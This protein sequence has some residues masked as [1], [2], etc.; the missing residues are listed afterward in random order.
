MVRCGWRPSLWSSAAAPSIV[1]GPAVVVG[2]LA[3]IPRVEVAA[4][5]D[6]LVGLVLA[7]ELAD[8]VRGLNVRQDLIIQSEIDRH[9][10]RWTM[11]SSSCASSTVT[12]AAGIFGASST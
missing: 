7:D 6:E 9:R 1:T 12:H 10:S 3:D 4:N 2:A 5:H 11:R 8:D